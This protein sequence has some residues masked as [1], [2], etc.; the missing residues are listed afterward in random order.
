MFNVPRTRAL[1]CIWLSLLFSAALCPLPASAQED[2]EDDSPYRPGLVARYIAGESIAMR[3]DQSIAFDW[4]EAFPDSR[5]PPGNFHADWTGRLWTQAAGS[6]RLAAFVAG[7]K[8]RIKLGDR[9][10]LAG[11]AAEPRWF[12]SEPIELQFDRHPLWVQFDKSATSSQLKLFWFGPGFGLEPIPARFLLHDRASTVS[13]AFERGQRLAQALRCGACHSSVADREELRAPALDKLAGNLH[14][15]WLVDWLSRGRAA[16]S[17]APVVRRMPHFALT[18]EEAINVAAWLLRSADV[19]APSAQPLKEQ[20]TKIAKGGKGKVKGAA[21][22]PSAQEGQRLFV[23]LGCLACHQ[24]GDLGE[25]GL[26]GGGDLTKIA[27]KRPP[28]FFGRWLTDPAS[29]NRHH[30]M[31]VFNLSSDEKASLALWLAEG[32][33]AHDPRN[34]SGDADAGQRLVEKYRCSACHAP[35]GDAVSNSPRLAPLT[36]DSRWTQSCAG[37]PEPNGARPGYH[38]GAADRDALK[39]YYSGAARASVPAL[40]S[41]GRDLLVELNC[42]ACHAREGIDRAT[43]SLPATLQE[44]LAAVVAIHDEFGKQVPA[45]TPP[46]L[47]S[48][49][50]K[51]HDA[52]LADAILRKGPPHRPYL[53]V[54]MPKFTLTSDQLASLTAYFTATDRIPDGRTELHSVPDE[55]KIPPAQWAA[56]GPRL[57]TTDGFGCT[58]CHQVGSVLPDKAPLNARGPSLSLLDKRIRRAWFDRWCANPA[59]IVPRMEMPSVQIPVRGVL[60][61]HVGDQLAAVW[62]VLNTPGFEPPEPNPV[63]VLRLSG[64]PEKKEAPVVL[65]DV[66]KAGDKTY[67]FPLVIGLPNRHNILFDLETNRLAAWWLGDTAR[68]RTKGKS[69]YWEAGS[70]SI[71]DPGFND[72]DISIWIDGQVRMPVSTGPYL[73]DLDLISTIGDTEVATLQRLSFANAGGKRADQK[74]H[75]TVHMGQLFRL[76]DDDG[77]RISM[78]FQR[79]VLLTGGGHMKQVDLRLTSREIARRCTWDSESRTLTLANEG[80][81][82]RV[83]RPPGIEWDRDGKLVLRTDTHTPTSNK[84]GIRNTVGEVDLAPRWQASVVLDYTSQLPVDQFVAAPFEEPQASVTNVSIA[85]GFDGSRLPLP[86]KMMPTAFT[87][88]T[89]RELIFATLKGEVYRA[90]DTNADLREDQIEIVADGLATPYG[91]LANEDAIDVVVK[92]RLIRLKSIDEG[93]HYDWF[94]TIASGWGVTDDYHDWAVG[95]VPGD[96][97]EYFVGLPCQQDQRSEA[98]A[99]HRGQLLKLVPRKATPDNPQTF[100]IEVL[101]SGH[102]FPM[103]LARN[104]AGELF[105]TDNQGNYN[106]F[107]ELNHVR[108]GAHFGFINALEKE[109]GFKPPRH[110]KPAIDIPH[111]WT[112]S[113]NGICFLDTPQALR[114][115]GR[116]DVFGPLEGHL[117]GC[118]YDT[119]Q[120]IRMTLQKVGDTYQGAAYP[121]S[122]APENVEDGLLGPIVCAVSPRGEL[123]VGNIRDSGWGAG[124]NVGDIVQIKVE[125]EKLPCGIAEVRAT[126]DGFT[127]DFFRPVDRAKAA[128]PANYSLS[129]YRRESTP[130]YGG[131]NLDRR[132]EKID[133]IELS[134]DAKRVTLRLANLRAGFLYEFQLKPLVRGKELFHPAEAHYTLNQIPDRAP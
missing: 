65:H 44:K 74:T 112:R 80:I 52:A 68:Q 19:A 64:V 42:L 9:D 76:R 16:A 100:D 29:L 59:R 72:S 133:A 39:A 73:G 124:N 66:I 78:G 129:S 1:P 127:L 55:L 58:S 12:L 15:S 87:W 99:R 54:Q 96:N 92:D 79:A 86:N 109:Q 119:R 57:V 94:Q 21:A 84:F 60:N 85:P 51:L 47:N 62:H 88:N 56:A 67:L 34:E 116:T 17:E 107:N 89:T 28:E 63:R 5:L 30:R 104:R 95:L 82:I 118:E 123:Y 106:P 125:P 93:R 6:Y 10:V 13:T 3:V 7:G 24:H 20:E 70:K 98:A 83:I 121:L 18:R 117:I 32:G 102:R 37:E 77:R 97:G 2:A 61:D 14:L 23:T 115:K 40:Q 38:L 31:P 50:D 11:D 8:C 49:G 26:F 114:D 4:G 90:T 130:A 134:P 33:A 53:L 81:S 46:A 36:A 27:A 113:V 103:G 131:P 48:V 111:P 41:R 126:K 105:V 25:S 35:A 71:F 128:D 43:N 91:I 122:I 132:I 101:S 108:P 22:K 120:L 75:N 45:M 69:W 110:D